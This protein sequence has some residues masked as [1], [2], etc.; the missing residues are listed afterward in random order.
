MRLH[1]LL[2]PIIVWI[3]SQEVR[4]QDEP[5]PLVTAI[6]G[7][8]TDAFTGAG[9]SGGLLLVLGADSSVVAEASSGPTGRFR[10]RRLPEGPLTL[11]VVRRGY[12]TLR[13]NVGRRQSAMHVWL[14]M[15]PVA[16]DSEIHNSTRRPAIQ[17]RAG[18]GS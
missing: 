11:V 18:P 12:H 9:I 10:V 14:S 16:A 6:A 17:E 15:R 1:L 4:Q 3:G 5:A 13:R 2:A 8:V 7:R